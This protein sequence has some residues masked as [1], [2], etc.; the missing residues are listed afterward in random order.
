MKHFLFNLVVVGFALFLCSCRHSENPETVLF[1]DFN[2]GA[3]V[4]KMNVA[5]L[6]PQTG[7][8]GASTA[9][10]ET[11]ERR[12][13]F[14]LEYLLDESNG[15]RFDEIGFLNELKAKL[16]EKIANAG[17]RTDGAGS[18]NDNFYYNYSKDKK[19]GSIEVIGTRVE[20]NKYKLWCVMRES[21]GI[22]SAK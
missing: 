17:V 6:R 15:E 1:R 19:K 18:T 16:A 22:D 8:S 14:D 20:G 9:I 21:A 11:T 4:E 10:G 3:T 5:Q 7:G 13:G 2:L 12:R